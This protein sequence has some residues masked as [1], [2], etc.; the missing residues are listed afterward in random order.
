MRRAVSR[1]AALGRRRLGSGSDASR[2]RL[3]EAEQLAKARGHANATRRAARVATANVV[4]LGALSGAVGLA[5]VG[6]AAYAYFQYAKARDE[7]FD[8]FTMTA[9]AAGEPDLG[10]GAPA[11]VRESREEIGAMPPRERMRAIV[12]GAVDAYEDA[13]QGVPAER[14]SVLS[15]GP[16][17]GTDAAA[18]WEKADPHRYVAPG[19]VD[20]LVVDREGGGKPVGD[21]DVVYL[22]VTPTEEPFG[23]IYLERV[24]IGRDPISPALR[25]ALV[26]VPSNT[27]FVFDYDAPPHNGR[28]RMVVQTHD[29]VLERL[30]ADADAARA[31]Q[32]LAKAIAERPY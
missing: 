24:R 21:G 15:M 28:R 9:V 3:Y 10:P 22:T 4:G 31:K 12:A 17:R 32:K 20:N 5:G 14:R 16:A 6:A 26:G 25:D 1:G 19:A 13:Q 27:E 23:R 7:P 8:A 11:F 30:V 18:A 29:D 2:Q